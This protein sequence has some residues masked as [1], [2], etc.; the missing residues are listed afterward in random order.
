[1]LET[2]QKVPYFSIEDDLEGYDSDKDPEF[3]ANLDDESTVSSQSTPPQKRN[4]R[5]RNYT[6]ECTKG[7]DGCDTSVERIPNLEN[8]QNTQSSLP[9]RSRLS[10]G[11]KRIIKGDTRASRKARQVA[12]NKRDE[13]LTKSGKT[14]LKRKST[15]PGRCRMKCEDRISSSDVDNL[16]KE[17]WALGNTRVMAM[18][19]AGL[20]GIGNT[21]T[22]RPKA[23]NVEKRHYRQIT[24]KYNVQIND[25]N[26]SICKKCC[27]KVFG[28]TNKFID[29]LVS[30]KRNSVS[31]V[32]QC[33]QGGCHI[34]PN[35]TSDEGMESVRSHLL[36]FPA[37]E[38][39]SRKDYEKRYLPPHFTLFSMSKSMKR[40]QFQEKFMKKCFTI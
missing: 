25:K 4:K 2:L 39:H 10:R 15:L 33:D 27:L 1:M 16:F 11:T 35:K 31:G 3:R 18:Y 9:D 23:E 40:K 24:V 37:Y 19:T 14:I 22:H 29:T 13:Y 21:A 20:L 7:P 32:F 38:S 28:E 5:V 12:R 6:N 17:Y 36:N 34:P 30:K 8:K 26:I